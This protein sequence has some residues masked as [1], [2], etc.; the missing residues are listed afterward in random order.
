MHPS[1][2]V[3]LRTFAIVGI[4]L[5]PLSTAWSQEEKPKDSEPSL[6]AREAMLEALLA[7][8]NKVRKAEDLPPLTLNDRLIASA[9][10]Q[11]R[12]MAARNKLTHEGDDGSDAKTRILRAGYHYKEMGE[13]VAAGQE[14]AGEAVET[15]IDSPPHRENLLGHFTEMGGG[16]A[17][18]SDGRYYWCVDYGRPMPSIDPKKS[19]GELIDALNQARSRAKKRKLRVDPRMAWV[20][21]RFAR[22]SAEH[23]ELRAHDRNGRSPL[24]ILKRGGFSFRRFA[25][26]FSSG[27][28]DPSVIVAG[29]LEKEKDRQILNSALDRIGVGVAADE[30]GVPYWVILMAQGGAR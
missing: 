29:W 1:V 27:E 9:R 26:T 17:R 21:E 20:A 7:S 15:W 19:P 11:A 23:G 24:D 3:G 2:V 14:T 10:V 13:N 25:I 22:D 4:L 6:A 18:G 16:V 5:L 12:D 8:H 30:E 28:A